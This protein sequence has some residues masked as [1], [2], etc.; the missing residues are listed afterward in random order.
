VASGAAL[1]LQ[2]GVNVPNQP[3]NL[4]GSGPAAA[5]QVPLQWFPMGPAPV[6]N[7]P[8]SNGLPGNPIDASGRMT[9]VAA[10]PS[11][12][13]VIYIAAAGGG[14][15]KTKNR[16]LSWFPLTDNV[17]GVP[18]QDM[19][20]GAIAVSQTNPNVI[21]AGTGEG[22]F[23]GDSYYGRGVLKST[24][25][26]QTWKLLG[27]SVFDRLAISKIAIDPTNPDTVFVSTEDRAV[28]GVAGFPLDSNPANGIFKTTDGGKTWSASLPAT[29]FIP[30]DPIPPDLADAQFTDVAINP[31]FPTEVW[32]AVGGPEGE[33][34]NGLYFSPDS[35]GTW[36]KTTFPTGTANGVI[37]LAFTPADPFTIYASIEN[38][39]TGG[40]GTI[41]VSH[42][43]GATWAATAAQPHNYLD[44]QGFYDTAI[45][46]SPTNP[47]VVFAAGD[48]NLFGA[49]PSNGVVE[50][51]DGGKTWSDIGLGLDGSSPHTD[52]HGLT[53]D[54]DGTLLDV[55][56]GGVWQLTNPSISAPVWTDLNANIQ[57]IE[58]VGIAINPQ[59]PHI[60]Y[61]G[62]QD[63]GR[64]KFTDNYTGKT[65]W[66]NIRGGDGGYMRVDF[67][68][69]NTIY[70]E[71]PGGGI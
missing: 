66:T 67:S 11:N 61:G 48:V 57:T 68:N 3:L 44:G 58:F 51:T 42:T 49:N 2:A 65:S 30:L 26:G 5:E 19:F 69:P 23:S 17:A 53:F 14:I 22:N 15:W 47:N 62:S 41:Q 50:T 29:A 16:G 18:L 37:R 46:V 39:A 36:F 63:N 27:N 28:N 71:F 38:A 4:Q 10:D 56:D 35:G 45:A 6:H 24:D 32:A 13:N 33:E 31:G 59:D 25:G 55:N 20:M 7:E 12:P 9:A 34:F 52:H 54:A 43:D 64:E 21:Y 8:A 70:G 40:L 1:E 60:A